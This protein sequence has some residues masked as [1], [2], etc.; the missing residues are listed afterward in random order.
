L[1]HVTGLGERDTLGRALDPGNG[2]LVNIDALAEFAAGDASQRA[3]THQG[4]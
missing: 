1:A 3:E 2:A 4:R